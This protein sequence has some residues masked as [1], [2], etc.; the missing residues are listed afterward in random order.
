MYDGSK[1]IAGLVVFLIVATLPILYNAA[2]GKTDA[3]PDLQ[4]VVGETKCVEDTEYMRA[5]HMDLL[6]DWRHAVVRDG[7]REFQSP[8]LNTPIEK[9]LSKTCL[10]CHT[11]KAKFCDKCHDYAGVINDCW[12]CHVN[13]EEL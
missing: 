11:S 4:K 9:S 3:P 6:D 10:K 1:I 5:N 2:L 7:E 8:T 12:D 13:P